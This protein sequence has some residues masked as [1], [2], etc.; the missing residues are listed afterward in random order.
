MPVSYDT[1]LDSWIQA[2]YYGICVV[3]EF[4]KFLRFIIVSW[5]SNWFLYFKTIQ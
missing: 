3:V 2:L 4:F 5:C 1:K